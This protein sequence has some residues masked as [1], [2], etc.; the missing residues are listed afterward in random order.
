MNRMQH[1]LIVAIARHVGYKFEDR[2]FDPGIPH[3]LDEEAT[4]LLMQLLAILFESLEPI[5]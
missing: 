3:Q 2:D 5:D 4:L 1:Q